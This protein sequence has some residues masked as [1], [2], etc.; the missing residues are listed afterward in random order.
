MSNIKLAVL[1]DSGIELSLSLEEAEELYNQLKTIF[2]KEPY[3]PL[4]PIFPNNPNNP[5]NPLI[6]YCTSPSII[7]DD[8][9]DY[10][11]KITSKTS[12]K[13]NECLQ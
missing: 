2:N 6:P 7:S 9:L 12:I 1:L 8:L 10:S 13:E 3:I 4:N 11:P 5:N